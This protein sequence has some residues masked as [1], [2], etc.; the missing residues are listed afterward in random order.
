MNRIKDKLRRNEPVFVFNPDF[1]SP[2]LVEHS[3]G[4]GFD[5]AFID[6]EHG[7]ASCERVEEMARA[8]RAAGMTSILRPMS[9]DA[10]LITRY[11]DCGVGGVQVPHVED[12]AGA[13]ALVKIVRTARGAQFAD[14]LVVAMIETPAAIDN[15]P[16]LLDVEG[17]DAVVVGMSDLAAALGYPGEPRRPEVMQTVDA[18]IRTVC[19]QGKT[20]GINLHYWED[21]PALLEKGVRWFTVHARTM[22]SRG[23]RE[24]HAILGLDRAR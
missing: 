1:P 17:L 19:A 5:A 22:L 6:C 8:A 3:G 23:T 16:E 7:S 21:G 10:A 13:R 2:A 18:V 11:L 4:L 20:I 12:A 15:L 9:N 14:T 24:L